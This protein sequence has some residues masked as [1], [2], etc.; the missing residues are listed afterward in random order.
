MFTFC[1][2]LM[3]NLRLVLSLMMF[4]IFLFWSFSYAGE[5]T[6]VWRLLWTQ[7]EIWLSQRSNVW[8][9]RD[10]RAWNSLTLQQEIVD[11]SKFDL[12][13]ELDKVKT[14]QERL[15][16]IDQ[17]IILLNNTISNWKNLWNYEQSQVD[18]Y[19]NEAKKCEAPIKWKNSEFSDA[20]KNYDYD[21]AERISKEIAELRACVARNE[22]FA[23]AHA[24]YASSSKS[25]NTLQ[26]RADYLSKNREK[27]AKYYEILKP[28]L[29]KELYDISK[30][31]EDF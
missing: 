24:S 23:K 18:Y 12:I 31:V 17:Y 1:S 19:N 27:I 5:N 22:V 14:E 9:F 13:S 3:N 20:V 11:Q 7:L 8:E 4:W 15:R 26:K 16:I 21:R 28:D 25:L 10:W 30:T 29:L 2:D 6:L